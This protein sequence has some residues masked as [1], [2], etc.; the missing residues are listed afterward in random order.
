MPRSRK[1]TQREGCDHVAGRRATST[2]F[3]GGRRCCFGGRLLCNGTWRWTVR[4]L[5]REGCTPRCIARY[6]HRGT[7]VGEAADPGPTRRSMDATQTTEA[8]N[9]DSVHGELLDCLQED[10]LLPGSRRRVRRR[11]RDSDSEDAFIRDGERTTPRRRLVLVSSTQVD[12]VPP[13]VFD[14]V[15]S[16]SR[17]RRRLPHSEGS[18]CGHPAVEEGAIYHD[19]TLIDS[20][21]DDAPFTVPR[22]AA[23]PARPPRFTPVL[24]NTPVLRH[25]NRF[26]PLSAEI[27]DEPG[28][29]NASG[30]PQVLHPPGESDTDS[31]I[32]TPAGTDGG[33]EGDDDTSDHSEPEEEEVVGT[34]DPPLENIV[35]IGVDIARAAMARGFR[36][37]DQIILDTKFRSRGC[38]SPENHERRCE[39]SISPQFPGSRRSPRSR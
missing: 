16:P 10:L 3:V 31:A 4:T 23:S 7:R 32:H 15:D 34:F 1:T 38:L 25:A 5:L 13:T 17:R 9:P 2:S 21:D 36:S 8:S 19:L 39:N 26:S 33:E 20:S 30:V 27:N 22:S 11:I 24:V 18:H 12:P 28:V 35:P 14:S 29:P 6:G 37:L